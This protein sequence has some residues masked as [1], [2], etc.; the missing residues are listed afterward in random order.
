MYGAD[1][2]AEYRQHGGSTLCGRE[3]RE[4]FYTFHVITF[5]SMREPVVD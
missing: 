4:D 3:V 2:L 5:T 1:E